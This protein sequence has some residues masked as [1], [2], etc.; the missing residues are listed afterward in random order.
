MRTVATSGL[1]V[2]EERSLDAEGQAGA[3]RRRIA[4]VEGVDPLLGPD[5]VGLGAVALGE[6]PA[7]DMERSGVDVEGERRFAVGGGGDEARVA[8]VDEHVVVERAGHR[9]FGPRQH[10]HRLGGHAAARRA[11]RGRP[12]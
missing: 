11:R 8:G 9:R 6:E 10:A 5:R 4:V 7:G 3:G 1:G 12:S 2:D